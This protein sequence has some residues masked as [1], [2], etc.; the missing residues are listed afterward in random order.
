MIN[1]DNNDDWLTSNNIWKNL[2]RIGDTELLS[3]A[4]IDF[5]KTIDEEGLVKEIKRKRKLDNMK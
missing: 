4:G 1:M 3:N 5:Q 2:T